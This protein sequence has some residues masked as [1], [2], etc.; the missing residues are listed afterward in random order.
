MKL[1]ILSIALAFKCFAAPPIFFAQNQVSSAFSPSDISGLTL[2]LVADNIAGS[3]GDPVS[4]WTASAGPNATQGSSANRPTLQVAEINGHNAVQFDGVNDYLTG[5]VLA[6]NSPNTLFVVYKHSSI[7]SDQVIF[8]N[9]SGNGWG[10]YDDISNVRQWFSRTITAYSAGSATTSWE[11]RCHT[12]DSGNLNGYINGSSVQSVSGITT[13]VS[14]TTSYVLG[15]LDSGGIGLFFA[16][17]IAEVIVYD[18]AVT[19]G[20]RAQLDTYLDNKY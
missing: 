5:T 18:H 6:V 16:G 12:L 10:I 7:G 3:D 9:G 20:E 15:T 2:W 14:P 8:Q 1:L 11:N 19:S 13:P 4:T 17:F